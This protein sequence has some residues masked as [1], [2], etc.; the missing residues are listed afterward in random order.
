M[1]INK[2]RLVC[3]MIDAGINNHKLAEASGI[4]ISRVSNIKNGANTTYEMA[5]KISK[6][7]NIPVL[8]L[9]ESDQEE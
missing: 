2:K 9:I 4:S 8:E 6:V 3:G 5:E 7:L 1:R